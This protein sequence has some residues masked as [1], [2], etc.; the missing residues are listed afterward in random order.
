MADGGN[1][2]NKYQ[3]TRAVAFVCLCANCLINGFVIV[4]VYK[5]P[6]LAETYAILYVSI[7]AP[8]WLQIGWWAGIANGFGFKK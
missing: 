1:D 3:Y 6:A 2:P 5:E 8:M 7:T 4:T